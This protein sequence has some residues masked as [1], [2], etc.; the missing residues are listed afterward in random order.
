MNRKQM[1]S[2]LALAAAVSFARAGSAPAASVAAKTAA[3][4]KSVKAYV[5]AQTAGTGIP[6]HYSKITFPEF[7]YQ[8]PYP[9]D[10]RIVLDRGV[11][12][13]LIPD[14]TLALIQMTVLF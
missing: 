8:P 9:K 10:Y 4:V 7:T 3:A 14:T 12:A 11:V 5:A 2:A 13:Y 1:V 6:E